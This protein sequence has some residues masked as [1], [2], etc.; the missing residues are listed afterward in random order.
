MIE[1]A[2][3]W[4]KVLL[5]QRGPFLSAWD[6]VFPVHSFR[7]LR[8]RREAMEIFDR[9]CSTRA[10]A[11]STKRLIPRERPTPQVTIEALLCTV[12]ERGIT[13]LREPANIERLS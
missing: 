2:I 1:A 5:V 10:D 13:A 7:T 12:R 4:R 6:R 9:A 11:E 3:T 8:L